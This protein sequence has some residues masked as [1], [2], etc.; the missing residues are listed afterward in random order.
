M[1]TAPA[2]FHMLIENTQADHDEALV[3]FCHFDMLPL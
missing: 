3:G 2:I 1:N